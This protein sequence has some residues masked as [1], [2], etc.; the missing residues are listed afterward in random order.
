MPH[1]KE[2]TP[3][4]KDFSKG[5]VWRNITYQ[6]LP[7][8]VAQLVQ[9]LY[10]ITDR[11]YIGRLPGAGSLA[12]TGLGITFPFVTLILAF[13]NLYGTGGTPLFS[14]ARGRGDEKQA[15]HIMGNTFTLL[16]IT[17]V[18]IMAVF[19][20]FRAPL[21]YLFGAGEETFPYAESYLKVYLIGTVFSMISAGM[22]GFIS[23]LGFPTTAM[24]TTVIG[25]VINIALDPI[26]IFALNLGIEGA[27][28][29]SVIGQCV[30]A[31]WV[32]RFLTGKKAGI[33][34]RGRYMRL[35]GQTVKKIMGLGVSGFTQ[36]ATNSLVQ[37]VCNAT[38]QSFGG[39]LYVGVMTVVN[40][41]REIASLPVLGLGNGA[42]PVLGYNYG[43]G[44][45]KRVKSGIKFMAVAGI[46]YTAVAWA[47]I[48]I[49]P[50]IFIKLFTNDEA[51]IEPGIRALRIYFFGFIFMSLQFMGQSVFVGL[52]KSG[53]AV[54][55]SLLRKVIIV[56]P[57]TLLLP[58]L[59]GLGTDGVFLAEPVS[60]ILGGT[61]C[62]LTMYFTLYKKL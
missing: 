36:Q 60:N 57:L 17:S 22:N 52:G 1:K 34:L 28:A 16:L 37:I 35:K 31:L 47:V 32:L 18:I 15:S 12:L 59:W 62:F 42:Q 4:P 53:R 20:I 58:M 11:V 30:S 49:F 23:A 7:L 14:M 13:S 10:N 19:Y 38:L 40:S 21:L 51:M 25:A 48:Q 27:A 5:K 33:R 2:N 41:V 55:F 45:P 61:A 9:L 39:D 54:F 26:F 46:T 3:A 43:A 24:L 6:A 8:T 29:A 56:V 50:T 44:Q